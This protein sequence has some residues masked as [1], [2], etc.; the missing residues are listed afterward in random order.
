M[1]SEG[2]LSIP[3]LP[4]SSVTCRLILQLIIVVKGGNVELKAKDMLFVAAVALVVLN[5]CARGAAR[6]SA[7][8]ENNV[9]LR[10]IGNNTINVGEFTSDN[11][12]R[13]ITCR[14]AEEVV[15]P[16]NDTFESYIKKAFLSE[17][18]LAGIYNK[19]SKITVNGLLKKI[20][21]VDRYGFNT[22]GKW[23]ISMEFSA[24]G[25]EPFSVT[26]EYNYD[27]FFTSDVACM[28]AANLLVPAVQDFLQMVFMEDRFKLMLRGD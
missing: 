9:L 8:V 13:S 22:V 2:R 26:K 18:K 21:L 4:K 10:S 28:Q 19:N 12:K 24:I 7:A 20:D 5:G 6:Y 27:P 16:D 14:P 15:L 17:L 1:A 11:P 3:Y 25:K 23:T